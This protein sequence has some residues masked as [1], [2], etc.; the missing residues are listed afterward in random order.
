MSWLDGYAQLLTIDRWRRRSPPRI[1]SPGE[2]PE[3]LGITLVLR[4]CSFLCLAILGS[5]S[6]AF[7]AP[8][9]SYVTT[10][11]AIAKSNMLA[12]IGPNGSKSQGAKVCDIPLYFVL[13]P[14]HL[15]L[16][17]RASSLLAQAE[18][19]RITYIRGLG[20]PP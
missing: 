2:C 17:R 16:Y 11:G 7:S 3:K 6:Y 13:I 9:D 4:M 14:T 1:Y 5:A 15:F 12:N 10:E 18:S 20:T 19:T 8:I